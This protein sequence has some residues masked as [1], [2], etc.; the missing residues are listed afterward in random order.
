MLR[1][2]R[3]E[4]SVGR[5]DGDEFVVVIPGAN[6]A[7]AFKA[8]ARIL[9]AVQE[10]LNLFDNDTRLKITASIGVSRYPTDGTTIDELL[11]RS[12]T[13][14]YRVKVRGGNAHE[15]FTA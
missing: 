11:A 8:A 5:L 14:M 3:T 9:Q 15:A 10:P 4:D 2:V 1:Q 12:D 7:D 6:D 13:A